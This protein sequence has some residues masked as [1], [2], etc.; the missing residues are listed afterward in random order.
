MNP[1]HQRRWRFFLLGTVFGSGLTILIAVGAIFLV[2][3]FLSAGDAADP[4][5]LE[6]EEEEEE[7]EGAAALSSEEEIA[8]LRET[9][10]RAEARFRHASRKTR[11]EPVAGAEAGAAEP[12]T[13]DPQ[14]NSWIVPAGAPEAAPVSTLTAPAQ[15][16]S[17]TRFTVAFDL[18]AFEFSSALGGAAP[19]EAAAPGGEM[20]AE[21]ERAERAGL[22]SYEFEARA[23]PLGGDVEVIEQPQGKITVE[24]IRVRAAP[25]PRA[26]ETGLA[27]RAS[28][29]AKLEWLSAEYGTG[30]IRVGVE[31]R[32][33]GCAAIALSLWQAGTARP[34]EHIIRHLPIEAANGEPVPG[35]EGESYLDAGLDS[36]LRS[37]GAPE[38]DAG[39]HVFEVDPG[40]RLAAFFVQPGKRARAWELAVRRPVLEARQQ[41]VEGQVRQARVAAGPGGIDYTAAAQILAGVLFTARP[42]ASQA[43][44]EEPRAA[45]EALRNM[46]QAARTAGQPPP[47]VLVRIEDR[48]GPMA[49]PFGLLGAGG[50]NSV[51]RAPIRTVVPLPREDYSMPSR[52]IA[53]IAVAVPR[54]LEGASVPVPSRWDGE[55]S[56]LNRDDDTHA[57]LRRF[58]NA[59]LAAPQPVRPVFRIGEALILAAHH[60]RGEIHYRAA[61]TPPIMAETIGKRFG[62]GSMAFLG[63]CQAAGFGAIDRQLADQLNQLGV[64]TIV[65]SPFTL[66]ANYGKALAIAF[67]EAVVAARSAGRSPDVETLLAEAVDSA[68]TLLEPEFTKRHE[69][70]QHELLIGGDYELRLCAPSEIGRTVP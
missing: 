60:G 3:L 25:L 24:L 4:M 48:D 31:P 62:P 26:I 43:E 2:P 39:F 15:G 23:V 66:D 6:P 22:T 51:L 5:D 11:A 67:A 52:C 33:A 64:D 19:I 7:G 12:P 35:C 18:A 58:L 38:V 54:Q 45:L 50:T 37:A 8:A 49:T 10:A 42:H 53:G 55:A 65:M 28:G 13:P 68:P 29:R 57:P 32:Q 20:L 70:M 1:T 27:L 63:V 44:M 14:W 69:S 59:E 9:L 56:W 16:D 61:E 41:Q 34:V 36:L 46:A 21:V 40:D 30:R 47:R 17:P